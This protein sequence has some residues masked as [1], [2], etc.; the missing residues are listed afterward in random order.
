MT[1]VVSHGG[2]PGE[3]V[4]QAESEPAANM[5]EPERKPSVVSDFVALAKPGITIMCL[6]MAAGGFGLAFA[7]DTAAFDAAAAQR[8]V[9][10][11]VGTALSV[12]SANTLNMVIERDGDRYMRRTRNRPLPSGRMTVRTAVMFGVV[13]GLL[14]TWILTA[15]VN[16][17][18][19]AL[20]LFALFSYVLVYTP[21]KRRTSTS[22]TV[23]AVPGAVPPLMGWTAA[24]GSIGAPGVALFAILF[25]WQL[26]H[27]IAIS[28]YR[29]RDYEAAGI[30]TVPGVRGGDA[31]RLHSLLW[32]LALVPTSLALVALGVAST[33]YLAVA[34]ALGAWFFVLSLRGFEPD[35]G[36]RWARQFFLASLVY[37]PVLTIALVL[38]V[39]IFGAG[40]VGS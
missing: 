33:L 4:S 24:T 3:V 2:V 34:G 7:M 28:L 19:A 40:G 31:A 11:L 25:V 21:L 29:A 12:A 13:T 23:G 14:S 30:K 5:N 37:L 1:A 17:L 27:F 6:I 32:S 39:L 26:P 35:S 18:T 22:V 9:A 36:N 8:F 15:F 16:P 10:M 20:G 38:D